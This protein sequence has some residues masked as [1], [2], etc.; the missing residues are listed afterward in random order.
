MFAQ[1]V[2]AAHGID[3]SEGF[4]GRH[5]KAIQG[6]ALEQALKNGEIQ[7]VADSEPLGTRFIGDGVVKPEA[8]ADQERDEPYKDEY[9]CVTVVSGR[10]ARDNPA[11][12]AKVT[13][14]LLKGAKWVSENPKEASE[15]SVEKQYVP[16][17]TEHPGNQYAG[18]LETQLHAGRESKCRESVDEAAADMKRAGLLKPET[19]PAALAQKAWLD[20]DGV[21]DE[22]MN[23]LKVE[24]AAACGGPCLSPME[25]AA[26]FVGRKSCCG[27]CCC[28][29][30]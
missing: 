15:L 11:A 10:L 23:G 28:V 27:H 13:R 16:S 18:S 3:P 19:D 22:W 7:A 20:L 21:T 12:A 5:W 2:L 17:S 24:K 1:R 29:G 26:L 25:F 8:V 9:C 30:E 4:Q 6:G 14:A